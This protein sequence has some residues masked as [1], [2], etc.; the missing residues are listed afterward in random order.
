M[1]GEAPYRG[2]YLGFRFEAVTGE[3]TR[4]QL[5]ATALRFLDPAVVPASPPPAPAL[6]IEP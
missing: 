1:A 2:V 5:L 4:A 6:A 3:E